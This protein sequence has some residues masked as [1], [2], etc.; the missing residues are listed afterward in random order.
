M[1]PEPLVSFIVPVRNRVW[2]LRS[3]LAS[4]LAQS[5]DA[6]EAVI[7]DDHSEE[8]VA[9]VVEAFG[10]SRFRY[11]RQA[12]ERCGVAA[13]RES[14]I[15]LANTDV[16]ITL[17]ADD[18]SHPHRAYRCLELL[19]SS[20]PRLVYTR[21][22][23]FLGGDGHNWAKPVFQPFSLP[24]L[25]LFNF[26][27]NP[28]TAFNRLAY[29]VAGGHFDHDLQIGEDYE[30][31]LRMARQGVSILGLDEEHVSY[32]KSA[33]S[34]TAGRQQAMHAAIMQIRHKHAVPPFPLERLTCYALPELAR[35]ILND[36]AMRSIWNDDR[37]P[38]HG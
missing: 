18:I 10:D 3:A 22:R 11:F 5:I 2:E 29:E 24:L 35:N 16:L 7:I 15:A 13:A 34:T 1:S 32:R 17:D 25:E 9:S 30:L 27:T 31:Y 38:S 36:P 6:W 20:Y 37:W 4:C 19:H 28:G 23:L 33:A 8:D 14:A 26:I 12:E 21:V